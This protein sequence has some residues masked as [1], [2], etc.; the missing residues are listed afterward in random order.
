MVNLGKEFLEK[1]IK[2]WQPYSPSLL[3]LE[4]ARDIAQNMTDLVL[5]LVKLEQKYGKEEKKP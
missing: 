2:V 4:D 3:S 5:L 1:T